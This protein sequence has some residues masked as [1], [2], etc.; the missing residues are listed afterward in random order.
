[1][2]CNAVQMSDQTLGKPIVRKPEWPCLNTDDT[3]SSQPWCKVHDA[4]WPLLAKGCDYWRAE[5]LPGVREMEDID[6]P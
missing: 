1:M 3:A 5:Q 6:T 2:A 4:P